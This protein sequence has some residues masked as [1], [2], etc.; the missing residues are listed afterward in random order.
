VR[1][2][3]EIYDEEKSK[4]ANTLACIDWAFA[5]RSHTSARGARED[6]MI[7]LSHT[8]WDHWIDSKSNDPGIDE[9]DMWVQE[10]G[11]VLERGKQKHPE[12]GG[13]T[14]YEELW[15]DLEVSPLGKKQNRS[16]MV[17]R[18]HKPER[19]VRGLVVKIGGWC[20]GML[21]TGDDLTVER[22]ERKPATPS[23][24]EAVVEEGRQEERT[25]NDWVR[26]FRVG[27]GTLPCM[28]VCSHTGGKLGLDT[29][30]RHRSP[31]PR[32][33]QDWWAHPR[34]Q[35]LEEDDA[36]DDWKVVEEYYW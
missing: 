27:K 13:E 22:W 1:L 18:A 23:D 32:R 14:E 33:T 26:T 8:V 34:E 10:D 7:K 28:Y 6:G 20:Q 31:D 3:C 4:E 21:K 15:H 11:D 29:V 36:Q 30:L 35:A 12:T 16:S 5:G 17:L 9:G 24:G 19:K 25:H 2:L